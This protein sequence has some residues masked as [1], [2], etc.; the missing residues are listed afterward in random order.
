MLES[1]LFDFSSSMV[2]RSVRL[3]DGK[4]DYADLI[5]M[6]RGLMQRYS[7]QRQKRY[8]SLSPNLRV[9]RIFEVVCSPICLDF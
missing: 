6:V 9:L 7:L 1:L 8:V 4:I 3:Q 2:E 5:P